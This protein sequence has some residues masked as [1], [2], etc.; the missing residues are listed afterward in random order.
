MPPVGEWDNFPWE[1]VD[2]VLQPRVLQPP[3][4]DPARHGE[5]EARLPCAA[6]PRART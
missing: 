6:R 5:E 4:D 2:G 1:V 3:G